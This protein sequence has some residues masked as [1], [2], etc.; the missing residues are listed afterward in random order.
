MN[1]L[2][3]FPVL[4]AALIV[5]PFA[6]ADQ[7]DLFSGTVGGT[8]TFSFILPA[9]PTPDGVVGPTWWVN[10]VDVTFDGTTTSGLVV[11]FFP[12]NGGASGGFEVL[13]QAAF[14]TFNNL[15]LTGGPQVFTGS[16]SAPTFIPGTY[17]FDG[18]AGGDVT[19]SEISPTSAT[20][21]P[22]SVL[23]LGT[24]LF[25]AAGLARRRFIRA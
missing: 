21:E 11:D 13:D 15:I 14:D 20:P 8:D 18:L 7:Q 1:L 6:H 24:G 19:I 3:P 10:G 17:A 22:S 16:S 2:R 5:V 4:L 12:S 23:L 25:G 9:S